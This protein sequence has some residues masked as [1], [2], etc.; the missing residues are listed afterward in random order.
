VS[1]LGSSAGFT[2]GEFAEVGQVFLTLPMMIEHLGVLAGAIRRR[3]PSSA[4]FWRWR[5]ILIHT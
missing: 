5:S 1:I 2:S 3:T 4:S